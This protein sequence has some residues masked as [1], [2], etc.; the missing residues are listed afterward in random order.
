MKLALPAYSRGE[1][2]ANG[3][4][5]GIGTLLSVVGLVLLVVAAARSGTA[6]DVTG[7]TIFGST[8]VLLYL[9]S[10]L[11]HSIPVL[12]WKSL[13]R[14]LDHCAIYLLI[15]G[16]Y[17]PFALSVLKGWFG[18]SLLSVVWILAVAGICLEWIRSPKGRLLAASL[19]VGMGWLGIVAI[20]PLVGGLPPIGTVLVFAGGAVYTLGAVFYVWKRLP[21]NHAIWHLF[22]LGGSVCHFLAVRFFLIP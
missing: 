6:R 9:A 10:T 18:W 17:T 1:E 12:R 7:V 13:L 15:A 8:L 11:Y 19:Y 20:R 22:V 5:H 3:V 2:I 16:T 4:T 21:Y 14:T